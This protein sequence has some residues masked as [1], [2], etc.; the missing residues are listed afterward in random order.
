MDKLIFQFPSDDYSI[1]SPNIWLDNIE[2]FELTELMRQA[3]DKTFAEALN[4]IREGNQTE[5]D[6][7]LITSR[8][9]STH[10]SYPVEATHLLYYNKSVE[11]HNN[12]LFEVSELDKISY[13]ATDIVIGDLTAEVKEKILQRAPGRAGDA[14]GLQKIYKTAVGLR[15]ELTVN[16][17][18]TDGLVNGAGGITTK[19]SLS[20]TGNPIII[21]IHFDSE[22]IGRELRQNSKR[23][24]TTGINKNWTPIKKV[25]SSLLEST[26]M[27]KS[28]ENSS[29]YSCPVL[30]QSTDLKE[31]PCK[32][33]LSSFL[34]NAE[35]MFTM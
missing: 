6:I 14:M 20:P 28:I 24:Y 32:K 35:H 15:N 16:L 5:D 26:K 1:L 3:G 2:L 25:E 13:T 23:L 29:H 19:I 4:N 34:L 21:W 8:T 9:I 17:D 7:T 10:Q 18:V 31:I 27:P 33:Q 12:M 22:D 30:K 11:Q